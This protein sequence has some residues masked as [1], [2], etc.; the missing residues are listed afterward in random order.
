MQHS[1]KA[2]KLQCLGFLTFEVINFNNIISKF[3]ALFRQIGMR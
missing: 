3:R 2:R 1:L